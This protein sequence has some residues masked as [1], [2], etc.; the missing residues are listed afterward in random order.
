[1]DLSTIGLKNQLYSE[2]ELDTVR[3]SR[4]ACTEKLQ[5]LR[6]EIRRLRCDAERLEV[7]I[8]RS[9]IALAPHNKLPPEMLLRIFELCCEEPAQIPAQNGSIYTV[10]HVCSLWRQ[11]A[12]RTPEFWANI[13]IKLKAN[14]EHKLWIAKQWLSRARNH[15]RSLK[16]ME[17]GDHTTDGLNQPL[18]HNF[19]INYPCRELHLSPYIQVALLNELLIGPFSGYLEVLDINCSQTSWERRWL[20]LFAPTTR[21]TK[22]RHVRLI[23]VQDCRNLMATIPWNQLQNLTLLLWIP[24][25]RCLDILSECASLVRCRIYVEDDTLATPSARRPI[26]LPAL[27]VLRLFFRKAVFGNDGTHVEKMIRFLS[28]PRLCH[29][30]LG[31]KVRANITNLGAPA[32]CELL[33]RSN[34]MPDLVSLDIGLR[35]ITPIDVQALLTNAPRLRLLHARSGI[36]HEEVRNGIATG[37]LTPQL[38]SIMTDVRHEATDI[39][40]MVELRQQNAGMTLVDKT[41]QVAEFSSIVFFCHSYTSGSQQSSVYRERLASLK[42]AAPGLSIDLRFS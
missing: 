16:F 21:L 5:V 10:S 38:R 13:S 11:I 4:Q 35:T 7:Q 37:T 15:P 12:L 34:G 36:F 9:D 14:N 25:S 3:K 27:R 24:Y 2:Q 30:T 26:T 29:L 33:Q 20:N 17:I 31:Q 28:V 8:Q 23:G 32:I 6:D 39:L 41:K 19:V 42:E 1:M 18:L 40:R 22:L